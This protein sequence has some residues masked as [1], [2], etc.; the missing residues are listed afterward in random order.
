MLFI[1]QRIFSLSFKYRAHYSAIWWQFSE[2][3]RLITFRHPRLLYKNVALE[4]LLFNNEQCCV[5][6]EIN[7]DTNFN[8]KLPKNRF[9]LNGFT[10]NRMYNINIIHEFVLNVL[11]MAIHL[12]LRNSEIDFSCVQCL[13]ASWKFFYLHTILVKDKSKI[14]AKSFEV[15][16]VF[17]VICCERFCINC[18]AAFCIKFVLS[19]T[20]IL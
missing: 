11:W 8:T 13:T 10:C 18:V 14:N 16:S 3:R 6:Y 2:Q 15:Q 4:K 7:G 9:V 12:S 1:F 20:I 19:Y 17:P 5:V